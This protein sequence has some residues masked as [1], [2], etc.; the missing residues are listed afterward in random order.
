MPDKV[1]TKRLEERRS[2]NRIILAELYSV[3][4]NLGRSIPIFQLKLRDISGH[5][6]CILVQEDSV[7]LNHLKVGQELKMK[8]WTDSRSEPSGFFKAQVKHIS[9]QDKGRFKN[10]SLIGLL[11]KEKHDFELDR[12]ESGLTETDRDKRGAV[13]RRQE[14][15]RRKILKSGYVEERRSGQDRRSGI[16]RRSGV[17]RRS[18]MDRRSDRNL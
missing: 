1:S 10:H 16:D 3:E 2:E 4:I 12:P 18:G 13:G 9:K 5:G 17:D 6:R 8:Y 11:I 7:I 14:N 15:D